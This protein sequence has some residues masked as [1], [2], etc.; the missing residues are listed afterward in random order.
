MLSVSVGVCAYNEEKNI[1]ACLE[2][3]SAQGLQ[4]FDIIEVLVVS[5]GSTDGTNQRVMEYERIDPRVRLHVQERRE[6]KNSAINLFL[7]L[8]K[9]DILV[10]VNADNRLEFG[11]LQAL[12]APFADDGVGMTGGHP[13]PLNPQGTVSGFAVHMLWEMHH[14]VALAHPKLG[15]LVAFR[16]L[17]ITL[18]RG[19]QSDEDI[20]CMEVAKRGLRTV[21]VPEAIVYN[22][23]P[24]NVRD[25]LK[26]RT[27]VN[28]GERY[29]RRWF[30]YETSTW[31][32]SSLLHAYG[33]LAKDNRYRLH[34]MLFAVAMEACARTY[35]I[36]H[37]ALNRGDKPMW[38]QVSSTKDLGK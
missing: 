19:T 29:M 31:D 16:H 33:S 12:L 21:Y 17:R 23:G 15:E 24:Q 11:S 35:A 18:P 14:R 10:L 1:R 36:M 22:R 7:D 28:I 34:L 9:A 30:H 6:G 4:G 37:V 20:I 2:S 38:S 13:V 26:Q 25:F 32:L 3:I 27:R 8:A 5:S